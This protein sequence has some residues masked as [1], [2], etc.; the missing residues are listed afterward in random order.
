MIHARFTP[1]HEPEL[2]NLQ[3]AFVGKED[4]QKFYKLL[5]RSLNCNPEAGPDWFELSDKIEKLLDSDK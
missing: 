4:I 3:I 1:C 5:Q 2:M